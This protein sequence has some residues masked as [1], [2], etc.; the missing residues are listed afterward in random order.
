MIA[1]PNVGPQDAPFFT[2]LYAQIHVTR[3][4]KTA[5][6]Q[7]HISVNSAAMS[8]SL[9]N[10]VMGAQAFGKVTGLVILNRRTLMADDLLKS[11]HIGVNVLKNTRHALD[12]D[13]AIHT[14]GLV[15]VVGHQPKVRGG[16]PFYI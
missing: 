12:A 14:A 1:H 13:T 6:A 16:F 9:A 11:D 3:R 8:A 5:A 7:R 4:L 10:Y 15:D 2:P